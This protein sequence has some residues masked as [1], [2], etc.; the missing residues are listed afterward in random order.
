M[1]GILVAGHGSSARHLIGAV[2]M[3]AGLQENLQ[4]IDLLPDQGLE[5]VTQTLHQACQNLLQQTSGVL[6]LVDLQGGTPANAVC[7]LVTTYPISIVSGVN[8]PMLLEV[9]HCRQE[10]TLEELADIA[11][12]SGKEAIKDISILF[13]ARLEKLNGS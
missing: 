4:P 10:K 5:D 7:M 11:V 13:K 12:R 6:A 8:L 3:I 2:E 9:L 1:I